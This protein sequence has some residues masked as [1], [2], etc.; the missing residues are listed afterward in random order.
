MSKK[1]FPV[2]I[3]VSWKI[4]PGEPGTI[5]LRIRHKP[6]ADVKATGIQGGT[7]VVLALSQ[8]MAQD[9]AKDLLG[10]TATEPRPEKLDS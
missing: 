6:L 1:L 8:D 10:I 5:L 2:E 3:P 7:T 4:L 9:L